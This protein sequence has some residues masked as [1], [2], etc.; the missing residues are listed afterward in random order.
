VALK[1]PEASGLWAIK[2]NPIRMS[3]LQPGDNS[4]NIIKVHIAPGSEAVDN[5]LQPGGTTFGRG[6]NEEVAR[7]GLVGQAEAAAFSLDW[8]DGLAPTFKLFG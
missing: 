7:L 2:I 8:T 4:E 6:R 3:Y 1:G 5:L